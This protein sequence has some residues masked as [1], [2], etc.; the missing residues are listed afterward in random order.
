MDVM[1]VCCALMWPGMPQQIDKHVISYL[2]QNDRIFPLLVDGYSHD[3]AAMHCGEVLRSC[4][5]HEE[6]VEAFLQNGLL[7]DLIRHSRH[8]S[9]DIAS[10]AFYSLREMLLEHKKVSAPW[11]NE[12]FQDFFAQFNG[13]LQSNDYLAE[14]QALTLLASMLLD[15]NFKPVMLRY[16][17]DEHNLMIIM[18]LLSDTS[19]AIRVEAFRVFKIFVANPQKPPRVHQI[20]HKNK[21][22]LIELLENLESR[23]AGSPV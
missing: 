11:L 5:R 3:V 18:N 17:H 2:Q 1:N 15:R 9:I 20:L 16:V 13:L 8:P 12:H 10:D 21:R 19:T 4:A 7:L 6:L 14:R 22:R 23:K